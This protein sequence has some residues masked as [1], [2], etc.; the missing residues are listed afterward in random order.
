MSLA[1]G[2]YF[3]GLGSSQG[4]HQLP[5]FLRESFG[6]SWPPIHFKHPS[7]CLCFLPLS[8][9]VLTSLQLSSFFRA[10]ILCPIFTPVC[11]DFVWS[12]LAQV[13][14]SFSPSRRVHLWNY[15]LHLEN[16]ASSLLPTTAD[17]FHPLLPKIYE[18]C[19]RGGNMF[20]TFRT[21]HSIVFYHGHIDQ[22]KS[23]CY[24]PSPRTPNTF[25][26]KWLGRKYFN[27]EHLFRLGKYVWVFDTE[28][29]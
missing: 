22:L 10:G 28:W 7:C 4:P 3:Q 1:I 5:S 23:L 29:L 15:L 14:C 19:G 16:A 17:F 26:N 21:G 11:L 20:N 6:L 8:L 18:I 27:I 12:K 13:F 25:S 9:S 24:M 2:S